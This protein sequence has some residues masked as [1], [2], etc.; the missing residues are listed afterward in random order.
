[1]GNR[2]ARPLERLLKIKSIDPNHKFVG[3]DAEVYEAFIEKQKQETL[4]AEIEAKEAKREARKKKSKKVKQVIPEEIVETGKFE[5]EEYIT[6]EK[7][8]DN[9]TRDW[10]EI[11]ESA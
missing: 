2:V 5:T 9:Q 6:K 7:S 1:M 10:P 3:A 4:L 8:G 11:E